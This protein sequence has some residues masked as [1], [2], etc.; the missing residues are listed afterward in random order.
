[1]RLQDESKF[2]WGGGRALAEAERARIARL[3]ADALGVFLT[4]LAVVRHRLDVSLTMMPPAVA[5]RFQA[6]AEEVTALLESLADQVEG[7][8]QAIT[9]ALGPLLARAAAAIRDTEPTL[10]PL[11][12]VHLQG[13]LAVYGDL[14]AR[15]TQL[16]HDVETP[17]AV[18]PGV[19]PA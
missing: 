12:Q 6:L 11:M 5:A 17:I 4:L 3:A 14:V 7:R 18:E 16:A 10:D 1:V 19:S 9:P 15:L 13:R 8:A 2:E